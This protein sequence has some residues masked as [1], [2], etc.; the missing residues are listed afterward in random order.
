M[1]ITIVLVG[2]TRQDYIKEGVQE[3]LKRLQAY[4]KIELITVREVSIANTDS[5]QQ[6]KNKESERLLKYLNP[7]NINIA[8]DEK[9]REITSIEF[10][11]FIDGFRS[12]KSVF[13][14]GGVYGFSE[15]LLKNCQHI[16]SMSQLTMTHQMIRLVFLEQLYRAFT[17]I[18]KKK[19]HY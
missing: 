14:I 2:K 6:V 17:I 16:L 9:G 1:K 5:I 18:H 8:L 11:R 4:S 10:S 19:Y 3:Y 12:R 13:F 7:D 15:K